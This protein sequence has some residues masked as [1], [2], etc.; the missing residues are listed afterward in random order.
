MLG[1]AGAP[2]TQAPPAESTPVDLPNPLRLTVTDE[3]GTEALQRDY[4]PLQGALAQALGVTVELVPVDD[5]VSGVLLLKE[6]RVDLALVGPSEYVVIR[7]RTNAVPV[8]GVTRPNYRS[9]LAVQAN[10]AIESVADLRGKTLALSD[11]GST[12][13]HLGP[14]QMITAAGLDPQGDVTVRMLGDEGS[15]GALTANTVDAWGGSLTDYQAM[16][17]D[18][19]EG[20]RV[21]QE[22]PPLPS[23]VFVANSQTSPEVVAALREQMLA[24]GAALT[25]AIA[26]RE[27]KYRG[28]TFINTQDSDYDS[29]RN[30]YRAIGQGAFIEGGDESPAPPP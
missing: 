8:I 17:A 11:V 22:G 14:I 4:G 24:E 25:T 23:D 16:V 12:S 5:Q 27:E 28:S 15:M 29:I 20:F 7:A 1:C 9:V 3:L 13:G 19:S 18:N 10:S 26:A 6:G 2:L 30:A 21:L